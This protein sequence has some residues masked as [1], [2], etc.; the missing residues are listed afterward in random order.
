MVN[1]FR[2]STCLGSILEIHWETFTRTDWDKKFKESS[3]LA[4]VD[5]RVVGDA[6]KIPIALLNW[7]A[8]VKINHNFVGFKG[9]VINSSDPSFTLNIAVAKINTNRLN[10]TIV[11]DTNAVLVGRTTTINLMVMPFSEIVTING[12]SIF[13][14]LAS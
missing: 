14:L 11:R 8:R 10:K 5:I 4:T 13:V 1:H 6:N 9:K 12:L 3:I 2:S 7:R